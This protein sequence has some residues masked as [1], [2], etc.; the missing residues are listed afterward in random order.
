MGYFP[1]YNIQEGQINNNAAFQQGGV[2][3]QAVF[4]K[5]FPHEIVR[6]TALAI[7]RRAEILGPVSKFDKLTEKL[8]GVVAGP[9]NLPNHWSQAWGDVERGLAF[10]AAGKETQ[11][12]TYLQQ[13]LSAGGQFDHPLTCVA[14]LELGKIS[15]KKGDYANAAHNFDEATFAAVNFDDFGVLEEAFR[16]RAI[17]HLL[18]NRQEFFAPFDPP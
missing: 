5:V 16:Y 18:S 6:C 7:R 13:S 11:G 3:Q 9:I 10:L 12:V 2:V 8:A 4:Y 15:L 14:L 1:A 17:V